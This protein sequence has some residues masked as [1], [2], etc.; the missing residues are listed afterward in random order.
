MGEGQAEAEEGRGLRMERLP[1]L[2]EIHPPLE[3]S[4]VV[5]SKLGGKKRISKKKFRQKSL[6]GPR[7]ANPRSTQLL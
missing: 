1:P 4:P 7:A 2:R 5:W 3:G 6:R